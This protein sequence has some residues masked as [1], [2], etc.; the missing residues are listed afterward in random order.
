MIVFTDIRREHMETK[1]FLETLKSTMKEETT[2]QEPTSAPDYS[3]YENWLAE[4]KKINAAFN[5]K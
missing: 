2:T 3:K 1:K 5:Q 4:L